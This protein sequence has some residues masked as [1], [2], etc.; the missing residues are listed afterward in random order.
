MA[1]KVPEY[2][3]SVKQ[4]GNE[5]DCRRY[6][7]LRAPSKP[8]G[9]TAHPCSNLETSKHA[10]RFHSLPLDAPHAIKVRQKEH[11]AAGLYQ[12]HPVG[13]TLIS[14]QTTVRLTP[15]LPQVYHVFERSV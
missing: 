11:R 10:L 13:F 2:T 7:T 14:D 6:E 15:L 5:G 3:G 1:L 4:G 12:H 8:Y 9:I